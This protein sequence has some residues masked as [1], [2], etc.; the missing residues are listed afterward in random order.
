MMICGDLAV[1]NGDD[2]GDNGG[3]K[4]GFSMAC[5]KGNPDDILLG[6]RL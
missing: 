5:D 6:Y 4:G 1:D 3:N 2:N